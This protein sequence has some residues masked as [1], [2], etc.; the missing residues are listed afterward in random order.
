VFLDYFVSLVGL[1]LKPNLM[2]KIIPFL[3][4]IFI[5]CSLLAQYSSVDNFPKAQLKAEFNNKKWQQA[6][7][8]PGDTLY[9]Q[10]FAGGVPFGWTITNLNGNLQD[11]WIWSNT[12]PGGQYS[13]STAAINSTSSLNGF[14][15][16]PSDLYNTPF[17]ASGPV[18][19][20]TWFTS[21]AIVVNPVKSVELSWQQS[22]RYCCNSS[23]ELVVEVSVDSIAWTTYDAIN[24]RGANTAMPS[25]TTD[26]AELV[27]I[28]ISPVVSNSDTIYVRFRMTGATH[29]YWM[30][31]DLVITEAEDS[32][33][34]IEKFVLDMNP[35]FSIKPHYT[36]VSQ[37]ILSPLSGIIQT[38]NQGVATQ[39]SLTAEL[40]IIQDSVLSGSP[41][42]GTVYL[43]GAVKNT[44]TVP[45]QKDTFLI[46]P[47][48]NTGDGYFR[49]KAS[50]MGVVPNVSLPNSVEIPFI[51]SDSVNARDNNQFDLNTGVYQFLGGGNN[52]DKWGLM[53]NL[54]T[55]HAG[56]G[57]SIYS[58]SVFVANDSANIGVG[59]K[60][61]VW[62]YDTNATSVS[63]AILM[64]PIGTSS[65]TT[66]IN[67]SHLGRWISLTLSL[68]L[69]VCPGMTYI[70]GFEQMISPSQNHY[71]VAGRDTSAEALSVDYS[72]FVFVNDTSPSWAWTDHLAG[73][74]MNT[75]IYGNCTV[76][77]EN[78]KLDSRLSIY[79]N[80]NSGVFALR[81]K[82]QTTKKYTLKVRNNIGQVVLEEQIV[83]NGNFAK[84]IDLSQY[85]SGIYFVSLENEQERFVEKV[86]LR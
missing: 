51:I 36:H 40:E 86:I 74:R 52:G 12:A 53:Y 25:I 31:D 50:V 43:Q 81:F 18:S 14:M 44:S 70:V 80:P 77:I 5:S 83:I 39:S 35:G 22:S 58:I 41:G 76:G 4:S 6:N 73:V 56:G 21:P 60:P 57:N 15:S 27:S 26:P 24:G 69:G 64:P 66:I 84:A 11:K 2:K 32:D 20:D 55:N 47:Y 19:M 63:N 33:M 16:L 28:N 45:L 68:P 3:L 7:K 42:Q 65:N 54:G 61:R 37:I 82:S 34:R 8:A 67:S 29:Y 49:A 75:S 10:D 72:N 1:N 85:E 23:D 78:Q 17:P 71:F 79:P 38:Q 48:L 13:S 30:I 46:G 9:Y 62:L 59:I